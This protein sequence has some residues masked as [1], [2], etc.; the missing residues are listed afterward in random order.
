MFA[1]AFVVGSAAPG[2]FAAG[3]PADVGGSVPVG[4]AVVDI[5]PGSPI[6]LMGYASRQTESQGVASPLKARALAIGGDAETEGGPALLVAVDNCAVG[7]KMIEDVA[8][9]LKTKV[10]LSRERFVICSTHTH[11]APSL[12]T[13]LVYIFGRPLPADQ[14]GRIERYTRELTDAL[15]KVALAA[16]ADRK[17]AHLAWGQGR[18]GFAA[19]R[20]VLRN[21]RWVNFGVNPNGP[22][23]PSLPVLRATD[24]AGRVR[25]VLF[26]YACHC[27]TLGG[28][29]NQ[30]CAEWAGF[31]CDEIERQ[32]PGSVALAIIGC[33][34]DANPEP[35]RDLADARQHGDAAAREVDR[36]VKSSAAMTALPGRIACRFRQLELPLEP[37]PGRGVLEERAQRPGAEGLLARTLIARLD[38]GEPLPA[39][40]PYRV[41]T[42]C[43]GD[44]LAMVF[45][46]GEVVVDY[47][48]RLK[49]EIDPDRLWIVAYSND[50]PCYIPS[51]R[52]L[53]E[54]GY[55]ADT[56]MVYYGHPSRFAPEVE[57]RI[58]QAVHDL[59]PAPFDGP[60]PRKP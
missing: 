53:S 56:S 25:A 8:A 42:W 39:T 52:I 55:E 40:V 14:A 47:A 5:T 7:A 28:E 46:A 13:E 38:R 10:G 11:C 48:L 27:T 2:G 4:V 23:D 58:I 20:R 30:I 12:T 51:R 16:L 43:F 54:G 34:A 21:G 31:A 37:P 3:Q 41:Q 19:N 45:L 29:F 22:V 49:W 35:R 17:P 15:E 6:R 26:G 32:S 60:R 33:G 50:V 18:V 59:L 24:A 9:R 57:D 44:E 36:L 1:W